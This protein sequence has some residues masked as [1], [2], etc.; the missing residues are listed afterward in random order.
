MTDDQGY[1]DFG[2]MG[3]PVIRTPNLDAM[4]NRSATMTTFYVS[5][6]CSPTRASLMTG[7]YNYRTRVVDTY[8]GRSMMDPAEVTIAEILRAHGY[9]TGIFGKWHLGDNYPMRPQDQGFDEVLVHRGGGIG[10]PSDPPGGKSKYSDPYLNH[11]GELKQFSGYITDILFDHAMEWIDMQ[12]E[13]RSPFFAYIATN[14]PHGPFGDVPEMLLTEYQEMNLDNSVFPQDVGHPL[15]SETNQ[16]R[17][18]K[19]YAMITNIDDNIGRLFDHLDRSGLTENTIVIFLNDNG[20][21]AR[22]YTAGMNGQKTSVREGGIR[23]PFWMHWP[24]QLSAE[25]MSAFPAAHIDVAPTILDAV[26]IELPTE[27]TFDGRSFLPY[28]KGDSRQPEEGRH[29]VIQS[30]RGDKPQRYHHFMIRNDSWKMLHHSGFEREFF[31]GD[32]VFELYD[33]ITDPLEQNDIADENP[34][35]VRELKAAYDDWFDDVAGMYKAID[36]PLPISVGT[37][38]ETTT[39]LTRIDWTLTTRGGWSNPEANGTWTL[40]VNMDGDYDVN[41]LFPESIEKG[42]VTLTI[43]DQQFEYVSSSVKGSHSFKSIYL[44]QGLTRI[45]ALIADSNRAM[46]AWQI[47]ISPT[48]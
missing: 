14:A 11:N 33:M 19:I 16:D 24:G 34:K 48:R 35:I 23:S 17:R 20:P 29:L 37:P 4:A 28:L 8:K 2:V 25:N 3:N 13:E 43:D 42:S 39:V 46:G 36:A 10:Q 1:G 45:H 41:L 40:Q 18:A 47:E 44:P 7:R 21:N 5:P 31:D 6:V 26:N 32:P 15:P 27:I 38:Y 9:R 22:R 12:E 30:H